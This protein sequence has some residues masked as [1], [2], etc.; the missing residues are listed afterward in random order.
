[1]VPARSYGQPSKE[2]RGNNFYGKWLQVKVTDGNLTTSQ[3]QRKLTKQ[4]RPEDDCSLITTAAFNLKKD[5]D[6]AAT[7]L[8]RLANTTFT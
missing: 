2:A 7:V 5:F 4:W 3:L 8:Q 1:M 6:R